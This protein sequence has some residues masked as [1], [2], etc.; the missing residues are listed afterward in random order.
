MKFKFTSI[1][2]ICL[3]VFSLSG[4]DCIQHGHELNYGRSGEWQ[5]VRKEYLVYR[6]SCEACGSKKALNVHHVIPY[7]LDPSKELDKNNLITLCHTCHLVFGHLMNFK[8]W[9]VE[10]RK[11]AE[12]YRNKI[13]HRP[14]EE[15]ADLSD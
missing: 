1:L 9:N 2:A 3:L 7:H 15:K 11:D 5:T 10:V 14:K 13:I 12:W 8:S 4:M 6:P